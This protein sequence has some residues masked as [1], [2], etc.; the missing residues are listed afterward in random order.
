MSGMDGHEQDIGDSDSSGMEGGRNLDAD[1][2]ED[3]PQRPID[4]G[5]NDLPDAPVVIYYAVNGERQRTGQPT[6]T[7]EEIL[8]KAGAGAGIDVDAIGDYYLE[9]LSDD[10]RYRNLADRVTIR[11]EDAFL[12]VYAGRTPVASTVEQ[13]VQELEA[14]NVAANVLHIQGLGGGQAI[15]FD[16]PV[17]V[18][19]RKGNTYKVGVSFQEAEY[20]EYPPHFI[21]VAKL[22]SPG[23]PVHSQGH[24][25]GEEW[26]AFSVPPNDF[27]DRLPSS[28]K[29]M[30]TYLTRHMRR[31]WDQV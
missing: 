23:L 28:D 26:S 25:D 11:H 2:L 1:P 8:R 10:V 12:A 15:V 18:G 30:K 7:V 31:F 14:L 6:M 9:H 27:W 24:H 3:E 22:Q 19:Q 5:H 20:P 13:V 17:E 29:N 16:Y 4:D 21:W